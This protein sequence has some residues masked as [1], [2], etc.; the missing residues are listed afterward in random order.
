MPKVSTWADNALYAALLL[1]VEEEGTSQN[2]VLKEA[3]QNHLGLTDPKPKKLPKVEYDNLVQRSLSLPRRWW[4][5]LG[6]MSDESGY[7]SM[8]AMIREWCREKLEIP[9]PPPKPPRAKRDPALSHAIYVE[10]QADMFDDMRKVRSSPKEEQQTPLEWVEANP[11]SVY[12]VCECLV[13]GCSL[14]LVGL[15]KHNT[16]QLG[17]WKRYQRGEILLDKKTGKW[18]EVDGE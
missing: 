8:M 15:H 17:N 1:R 4:V 5:D 9:L 10:A 6:V 7:P 12:Q 3:L 2:A 13:E 11:K 16:D 18:S 14:H